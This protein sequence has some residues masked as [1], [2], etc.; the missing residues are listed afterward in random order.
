MQAIILAAGKGSR[1]KHLTSGNTKCMIKVNGVTLIERMLAALDRCALSRVVIVVGYQAE[2][3]ID[4]IAGLKVKTPIVYV[5]NEVYDVTNNIYSLALASDYL[6]RED[7]LILES[8]LIFEQAVLDS[9]LGD[10][11]EDLALVDRYR[12]WM[13][14]TVLTLDESDGIKRFVSKKDFDFDKTEH[15]FKTVNIYKFSADFSRRRYVPYLKAYIQ[16]NGPNE[17]YEQVLR[18]ITTLD[19]PIIQAKRL[20]GEKWYEIDDEQDLDIAESIFCTPEEKLGKMA[21]RYGGYWR[22]PALLDFC[23]LVNPLFPGPRLIRELQNS[24]TPLLVNYPS[25][26]AVNALVA[27]KTFGL[28]AAHVVVGNGAAEIIK[29]LIEGQEGKIGMVS[30]TFEEYPNRA[31][32]AQRVYFR[33]E[34]AD[35]RY[36]ARELIDFFAGRGLS[37]LVL[38]NPD[39]PTGHY[40]PRAEVEALADWCL[41]QGIRLIY[42]E[43]FIDFAEEADASMLSEAALARWPQMLVV[44]S[45][46]KSYGVPGL[47]LGL[48]AS[49][50]ARLIAELKKSLAIWNINSFGEYFLQ[51]LEKYLRDYRQAL[52][53]F[54][55]LRAAFA[56]DLRGIPQLRLIPSQANYFMLELRAGRAAE[57]TEWLLEEHQILIKDLTPK[58]KGG[59]QY[60]RLAVRDAADNARLIEA[61]RAY[62]QAPR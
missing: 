34:N 49:A 27:A 48:A 24:F 59:G 21:A 23:Y 44:K 13:D 38:I 26:Q 3:L 56:E 17:Y 58:V 2:P 7:S 11:R 6:L 19:E 57:L 14:G 8:D 37:C 40:L 39:N 54:K 15:Y 35:F 9:I 52:E 25:G 53:G 55:A 46:S 31:G 45:I 61:L 47:R 16:S 1:L 18:L 22:Y 20:Q 43:S 29:A 51:I 12:P 50:D 33:P 36:S 30:P 60:I 42:D 41:E 5:R 62:W 10:E 32:E 28:L 4:F